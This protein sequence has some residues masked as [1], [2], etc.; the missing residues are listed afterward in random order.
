[1][2]LTLPPILAGCSFGFLSLANFQFECPRQPHCQLGSSVLPH[3][4]FFTTGTQRSDTRY[5]LRRRRK[6]VKMGKNSRECSCV[7]FFISIWIDGW[8]FVISSEEENCCVLFSFILH[9]GAGRGFQSQR[10]G[11][12]FPA[13]GFCFNKEGIL[14]FWELFYRFIKPP[15]VLHFLVV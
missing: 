8:I 15:E 13:S 4:M 1:M 10:A 14:R 5:K 6:R 2:N 11:C 12:A 7:V 9:R 3:I